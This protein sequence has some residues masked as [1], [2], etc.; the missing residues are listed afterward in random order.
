[1]LFM[2]VSV[3]VIHSFTQAEAII[4]QIHG[5]TTSIGATSVQKAA[6]R[7]HIQKHSVQRHRLIHLYRKQIHV[8]TYRNIAVQRHRLRFKKSTKTPSLVVCDTE[9][10]R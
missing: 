8:S 10:D 7:I 2:H 4:T 6:T 1:M 9:A 3:R 5:D